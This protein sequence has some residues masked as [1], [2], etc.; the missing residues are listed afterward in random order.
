MCTVN[1]KLLVFFGRLCFGRK[2]LR[3]ASTVV[4]AVVL[5]MIFELQYTTESESG[6]EDAAVQLSAS[7][8]SHMDMDDKS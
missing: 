8:A 5:A 2:T 6:E 7:L 4:T 3:F 1:R